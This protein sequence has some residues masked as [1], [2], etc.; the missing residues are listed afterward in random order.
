[1]TILELPQGHYAD[2][3]GMSLGMVLVMFDKNDADFLA[4]Y[5]QCIPY[6]RPLWRK[7][8]VADTATAPWGHEWYQVGADGRLTRHSAHYDSSD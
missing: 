3:S 1:M 4:K 6:H 7:R 2:L 5:P 8:D